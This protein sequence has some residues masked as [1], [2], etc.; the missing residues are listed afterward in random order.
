MLFVLCW[1]LLGNFAKSLE[2][3][4]TDL[5]GAWSPRL[6]LCPFF[7]LTCR[8]VSFFILF[9]TFWLYIGR[10]YLSSIN[11][12]LWSEHFSFW[13]STESVWIKTFVGLLILRVLVI[14]AMLWVFSVILQ[15]F[16][17]PQCLVA[18]QE[19]CADTSCVP[20]GLCLDL[21]KNLFFSGPA[22]V[23]WLVTMKS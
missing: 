8:P 2:C 15:T 19:Q 23:S 4:T 20:L 18:C 1:T 17:S 16:H 5:L 6:Y 12:R 13:S 14:A 22:Q 21:Q 3:V 7:K 10:C 11:S 9:L